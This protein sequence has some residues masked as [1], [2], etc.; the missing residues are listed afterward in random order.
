VPRNSLGLHMI[1]Y[2]AI[3]LD[4]ILFLLAR[5]LRIRA[6][7]RVTHEFLAALFAL[8]MFLIIRLTIFDRVEKE[9]LLHAVFRKHNGLKVITEAIFV[10]LSAATGLQLHRG[11]L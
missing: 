7:H 2:G 10:R 8:Q 5:P 11:H 6:H 3:S 1:L 4:G 9:L